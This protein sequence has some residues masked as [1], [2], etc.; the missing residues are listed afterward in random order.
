MVMKVMMMIIIMKHRDIE[1]AG[2]VRRTQRSR[3][4]GGSDTIL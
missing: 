4:M 1:Q 2:A 3:Y